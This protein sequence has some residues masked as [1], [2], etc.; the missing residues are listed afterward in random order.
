[1]KV[2]VSLGREWSEPEDLYMWEIQRVKHWR[3][4][5]QDSPAF[6]VPIRISLESLLS[7]WYG[8]STHDTGSSSSSSSSSGVVRGTTG[9]DG[10]ESGL[11]VQ[12]SAQKSG[13][14]KALSFLS[15]SSKLQDSESEKPKQ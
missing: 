11:C 6:P 5:L 3:D 10:R 1:M 2:R 13:L 7:D 15:G 9:N 12:P 4:V 14:T 8:C